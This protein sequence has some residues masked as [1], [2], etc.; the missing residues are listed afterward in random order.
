MRP[1]RDPLAYY[2]LLGVDPSASPEEIRKA[3]RA[4]AR[5]FHPDLNS[6]LKATQEF[7]L[8]G[9]AYE[10]L[11][12]E[13]SRKEYDPLYGAPPPPPP[14][15]SNQKPATPKPPPPPPSA[16]RP[17]T[18][19]QGWVVAALAVLMAISAVMSR[20]HAASDQAP[21]TSS[22]Q[23]QPHSG[24]PTRVLTDQ[25]SAED[26][27]MSIPRAWDSDRSIFTIPGTEYTASFSSTF[28]QDRINTE[29]RC[30]SK[31]LRG[32]KNRGAGILAVDA[33]TH[34]CV[35]CTH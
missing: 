7:Q 14:P 22:A 6:S 34:V 19:K 33:P 15:K 16:I 1:N 13:C 25:T 24:S 5:E 17:T 30:L 11:S 12:D 31:R 4:A 21:T 8:L 20:A 9:R 10:V 35:T 3:Y 2:A 26:M 28:T 27:G 18:R 32:M 29:L 23:P